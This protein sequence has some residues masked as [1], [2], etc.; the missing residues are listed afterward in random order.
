MFK[1]FSLDSSEAVSYY[2]QSKP[3]IHLV[4]HFD[5]CI[6]SPYILCLLAMEL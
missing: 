5:G 1:I 4:F 3:T 6:E 2:H